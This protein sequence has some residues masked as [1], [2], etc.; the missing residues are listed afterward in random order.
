MTSPLPCQDLLA[1]IAACRRNGVRRL[2]L[3]DVTLEFDG[4]AALRPA[5]RADDADEYVASRHTPVPAPVPKRPAQKG[6]APDANTQNAMAVAAMN[7]E[8][9]RWTQAE[10]PDMFE[11][12]MEQAP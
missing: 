12:G 9:D 3:A 1:I 6:P 4:A 8:M 2:A 10:A 5:H 7:S 11:K